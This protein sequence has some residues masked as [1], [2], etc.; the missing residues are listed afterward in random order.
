ML[1]ES[2][3]EEFR[4]RHRG[5]KN[6]KFHGLDHAIVRA[7]IRIKVITRKKQRLP[8]PFNHLKLKDSR[9]INPFQTLLL[10]HIN[11]QWHLWDGRLILLQ[12]KA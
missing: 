2:L 8:K 12:L 4:T 10:H 9:T 6:G 3:L 1:D 5:I 11:K 7:K